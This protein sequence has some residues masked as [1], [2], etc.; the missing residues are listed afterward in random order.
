MVND[1]DDEICNPTVDLTNE[2]LY[3]MRWSQWLQ[4]SSP[5]IV[6]LFCIKVRKLLP[7]AQTSVDGHRPKSIELNWIQGSSVWYNGREEMI[8][9]TAH[10]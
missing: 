4:N 6:L 10:T 9:I 2:M 3:P 1:L 8:I 7:V 5:L